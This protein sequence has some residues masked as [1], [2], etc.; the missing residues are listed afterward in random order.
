MPNKYFFSEV[1]RQPPVFADAAN[2][3]IY[4]K[5][6]SIQ[7]LGITED[8]GTNPLLDKDKGKHTTLHIY[9]D[10]KNIQSYT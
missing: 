5:D 8:P 3:T 4:I 9:N 1:Y 10:R 6:L 2:C 7:D